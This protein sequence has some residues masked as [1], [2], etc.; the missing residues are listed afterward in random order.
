MTSTELEQLA[1]LIRD[2]KYPIL[3]GETGI[4]AT[5]EGEA[6]PERM[7]L[8]AALTEG[9]NTALARLHVAEQKLKIKARLERADSPRYR[10]E[11]HDAQD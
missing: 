10:K 11:A 1:A 6:W 2:A 8:F 3:V 9:Y 5:V 7:K 4:P